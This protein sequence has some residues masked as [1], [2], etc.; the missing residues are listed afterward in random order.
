MAD[1]S[2]HRIPF[3]C[4]LPGNLLSKLDERRGLIPRTKYLE[5]LI[6]AALDE[7]LSEELRHRSTKAT[8]RSYK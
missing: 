3:G 5:L 6:R 7:P 2:E 8:G 4:T 1:L